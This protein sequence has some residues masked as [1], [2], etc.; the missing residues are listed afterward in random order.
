MLKSVFSLSLLVLL[1]VLWSTPGLAS[2]SSPL[3]LTGDE[4]SLSVSAN[5]SI[6]R[7]TE[8]PLSI[9]QVLARYRNGRFDEPNP[10]A[11]APT[12][13]GLTTDQIWLALEFTAP[14]EISDRWFVEIGHAS[15]DHVQVYLFRNGEQVFHGE[16]GDRLPFVS[17]V[18]SHRNHV[19]RSPCPPTRTTAYS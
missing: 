6:Y 2:S 1:V 4:E 16:S 9:D 8:V 18:V 14:P 7:S 10:N 12:N 13:F 15:L 11:A 19:F 5:M 17:K 3:Q